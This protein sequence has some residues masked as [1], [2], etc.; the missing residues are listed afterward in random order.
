MILSHWPLLFSNTGAKFVMKGLVSFELKDNIHGP[1]A[2][3][4]VNVCFLLSGLN[5]GCQEFTRLDLLVG[6]ERL[7]KANVLLF[8][9]SRGILLLDECCR[10]PCGEGDA[11]SAT[12]LFSPRFF[13]VT[14]IAE[15]VCT[16]TPC[17]LDTIYFFILA[18][19]V[20]FQCKSSSK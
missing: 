11:L 7:R 4:W 16:I 5:A 18:S 10:P 2:H 1:T 14:S 12:G 13:C 3:L 15:L 20:K 6:I 8:P 19:A 17:T 9:M